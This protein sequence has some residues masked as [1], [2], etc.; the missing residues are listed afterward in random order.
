ML[1]LPFFLIAL[2]AYASGCNVP[3]QHYE[4]MRCNPIGK[5]TSAGCPQRYECPTLTTRD[6]TKCYFHGQTY[7][8]DEQ[9]PNPEVAHQ[10]ATSCH[11]RSGKPFARIECV[12]IECPEGFKGY[13]RENCVLSYNLQTCC[14]V[15]QI[16]GKQRSK[17][18]KC[19]LDGKTYLEKERMHPAKDQC[20]TCICHKKFQ[21]SNQVIDPYCYDSICDFELRYSDKLYAGAAPV[22]FKDSCCP[23]LWKMPENTDKVAVV[24]GKKSVPAAGPQ[25]SAMKCKFGKLTLNV[26]DKLEPV[27]SNQYTYQ[28]SC[29]VPPMVHCIASVSPS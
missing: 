14:S 29:D 11:C 27:R 20:R 19:T 2:A 6:S 24:S 5:R 7:R 23:V 26:G 16:C 25:S 22:Y 15:G 17:T 4:T 18:H 28:C 1:A 10:C 13:D 12:N 9:I 8:L 21:E 3:I